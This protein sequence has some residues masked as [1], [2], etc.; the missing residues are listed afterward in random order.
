MITL[1]AYDSSLT[2]GTSVD[3][4]EWCDNNGFYCDIAFSLV[5][6]VG[7]YLKKLLI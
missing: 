3:L 4:K 1:K 5:P 6:Y 2:S 7:K